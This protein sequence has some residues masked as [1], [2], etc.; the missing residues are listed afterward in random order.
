MSG[1]Y[2]IRDVAFILIGLAAVFAFGF[3]TFDLVEYR[4]DQAAEVSAN[5]YRHEQIAQKHI[6]N[7]CSRLPPDERLVCISDAFTAIAEAQR[8]T[9]DLQAQKE[10]ARTSF[11][12][13]VISGVQVL[14]GLGGIWFVARTLDKTGEAVEITRLAMV[15]EHRPWIRLS[16]DAERL[17]GR[18]IG[19]GW[20][21]HTKSSFTNVGGGVAQRVT[22]NYV[23]LMT[24]DDADLLEELDRWAKNCVD[25]YKE[26]PVR[27]VT[28][29]PNDSSASDQTLKILPEII[30][31]GQ[32]TKT[33]VRVSPVYAWSAV[34]SSGFKGTLFQT[35]T[36]CRLLVGFDELTEYSVTLGEELNPHEVLILRPL[37]GA[38]R[39]T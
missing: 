15:A 10:M 23:E 33:G 14:L 21:L 32:T 30:G 7:D 4:S 16:V 28:L 12:M 38:D 8:F 35:I 36:A 2:R 24:E 18:V 20:V 13:I 17:S 37:S 5:S 1:S 25:E 3:A 9:E 31:R 27:G 11:W 34:Y 29:F 26:K 22:I 19:G 39:A 6:A